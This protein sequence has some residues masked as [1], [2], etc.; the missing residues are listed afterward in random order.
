M[1]ASTETLMLRICSYLGTHGAINDAVFN[2]IHRHFY[3]HSQ[4]NSS[5]LHH[6][7]E[8]EHEYVSHFCVSINEYGVV[9]DVLTVSMHP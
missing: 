5:T 9:L 1:S 7:S 2:N 8:R 4:G 3:A 6:V